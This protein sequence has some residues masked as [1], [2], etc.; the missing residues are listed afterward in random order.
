[1]YIATI[2]MNNERSLWCHVKTAV[3]AGYGYMVLSQK[4]GRTSL[5]GT[6]ESLKGWK[7]GGVSFNTK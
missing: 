1:M 3:R 5:F 7:F 2:A 4:E 6:K